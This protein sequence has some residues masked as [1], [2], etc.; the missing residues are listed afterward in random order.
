MSDLLKTLGANRRDCV[1]FFILASLSFGYSLVMGT[2]GQFLI[3]NMAPSIAKGITIV[4]IELLTLFSVL[5]G[6]ILAIC[7]LSVLITGGS[8]EL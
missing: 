7:G 5:V 1:W 8:S 6:A 4:T 3:E 2:S